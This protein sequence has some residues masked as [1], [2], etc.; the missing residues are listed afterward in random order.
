MKRGKFILGKKYSA[1]IFIFLFVIILIAITYLT[2]FLGK[3]TAFVARP[4]GLNITIGVPTIVE[5]WNGTASSV[6]ISQ[7]PL[8]TTRLINF[9]VYNSVGTSILND[10][11][12]WLNIT[13]PGETRNVTC[14]R[15]GNANN[16][17]NYTCNL[18]MFWYDA[19]GN[20]NITAYIMDNNTNAAANSS[21]TL[22]LGSTTSFEIAPTNL[23]WSGMGPG[24]VNQT[25]NNDPFNLTNTGNQ[26][27]GTTTGTSNISINATDLKGE[28]NNAYSLF[29]NNFSVGLTTGGSPPAECSDSVKSN[30]SKNI[31][32]NVSGAFLPKGNYT[33]GDTT[34]GRD[35]LYFCLK[36]AGSDLT[37]Q[38]YSTVNMSAWTVKIY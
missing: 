37:S 17:A 20:W 18:T 14:T 5:V 19:S 30:F 11:S 36:I 28:T 4:V 38:A 13:F 2:G 16:Y 8:S 35:Q 31:F 7:G 29:A 1:F 15:F 9:T 22:T 12:A 26:P 34:T 3:I 25:S 24:A 10:T 23:T 33:V 32:A 21:T 6:T 27:V